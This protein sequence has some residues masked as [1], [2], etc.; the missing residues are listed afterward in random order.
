M[1]SFILSFLE[2]LTVILSHDNNCLCFLFFVQIEL[3]QS[4]TSHLEELNL[5][6]REHDSAVE[7][8][9]KAEGEITKLK[10]NL[11]T[12]DTDV[13]VREREREQ[14]ELQGYV[15]VVAERQLATQLGTTLDEMQ[16]ILRKRGFVKFKTEDLGAKQT[17]IRNINVVAAADAEKI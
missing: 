14:L 7:K 3:S 16:S 8:L 4:A 9:Q 12:R 1:F 10:E 5:L 13:K 15:Y 2:L 17:G 6:L 11:A